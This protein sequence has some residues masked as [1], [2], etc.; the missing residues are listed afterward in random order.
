[1]SIED[2]E[3]FW[4][5]LGVF[6]MFIFFVVFPM[7]F[8]GL[9]MFEYFHIDKSERYKCFK[10]IENEHNDYVLFENLDVIKGI[11]RIFHMHA[12]MILKFMIVE[13]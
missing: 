4:E 10:Y 7:T 3:K 9:F 13:T 11:P 2:F 6:H 5:K 8:I 12:P 1:M